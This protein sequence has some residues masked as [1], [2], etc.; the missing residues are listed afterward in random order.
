M[1]VPGKNAFSLPGFWLQKSLIYHRS[2]AELAHLETFTHILGEM[3]KGK[4]VSW[5]LDL[6]K[7]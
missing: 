5:M 4:W 3:S 2:E 7:F 1:M 6:E